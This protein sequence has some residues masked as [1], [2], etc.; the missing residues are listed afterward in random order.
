MLGRLL[1]FPGKGVGMLKSK[2]I[3]GVV[4]GAAGLMIPVLAAAK[5]STLI[6]HRSV[7]K[8]LSASTLKKTTTTK[9]LST[10]S[11]HLHSTVRHGS[12]LTHSSKL[13]HSGKKLHTFRTK[14]SSLSS[15]HVAHRSLSTKKILAPKAM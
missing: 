2:W 7:V 14:H 11:R 12:K 3:R 13:M 15:K 5:T 6:R 4:I 9:K 8:P 10:S 1:K